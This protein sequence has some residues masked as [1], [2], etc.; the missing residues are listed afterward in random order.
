M[1]TYSV[2]VATYSENRLED[3]KAAISSLKNQLLMPQ[4][5]IIVVD[6]N[7]SLFQKT[8]TI[9]QDILIIQ[10]RFEQGASGSRNTGILAS[11]GTIVAFLDDDCIASAEWIV[12]IDQSF[13]DDK[14]AGIGGKIKPIWKIPKPPWFPEEFGWVLGITNKGTI[15]KVSQVRNVWSGNMAVRRGVALSVTGF[16]SVFSKIGNKPLPE[17]TDFCVRVL[18]RWP[19]HYWLFNPCAIV[20]HKI[21][22][23]RNKLSYFIKRCFIEG[24]GKAFMFNRAV[25]KNMEVEINYTIHILS[26]GLANGLKDTITKYDIFGLIRSGVIILGFFSV[27]LGFFSKYIKDYSRKIVNNFYQQ[28]KEEKIKSR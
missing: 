16:N 26:K 11:S 20:Y 21:D 2:V 4:E 8:L 28:I 17:D 14:A 6:H 7:E 19:G 25:L 27:G 18:F 23:N 22:P 12:N 1:N 15:E 10:N 13:D 3:L 5:I 9:F 24:K